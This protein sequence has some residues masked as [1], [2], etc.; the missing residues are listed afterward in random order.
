M[1]FKPLPP[2]LTKQTLCFPGGGGYVLQVA[3][4]RIRRE[5]HLPVLRGASLRSAP[6][7]RGQ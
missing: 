6:Q 1:V 5:A 3:R 4:T 2:A 7:S